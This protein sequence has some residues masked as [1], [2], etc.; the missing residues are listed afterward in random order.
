MTLRR[1]LVHVGDG[2]TDF[3][4]DAQLLLVVLVRVW[5]FGGAILLGARRPMDDNWVGRAVCWTGYR[6]AA[7]SSVDALL[8]LVLRRRVLSLQALASD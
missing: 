2:N 7:R 4:I 1:W 8:Q 3:L 5:V 6:Q